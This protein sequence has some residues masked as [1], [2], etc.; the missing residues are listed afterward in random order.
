M[1]PLHVV[2]FVHGSCYEKDCPNPS[3]YS[4]FKDCS[5]CEV[6]DAWKLE[7]S[8]KAN[9]LKQSLSLPDGTQPTQQL[10][11]DEEKDDS[12]GPSKDAAPVAPV[13]PAP[14]P[15]SRKSGLKSKGGQVA[16][17]PPKKASDY[18]YAAS[19]TATRLGT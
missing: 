4:Y 5:F 9:A 14:P 7:E 16:V 18:R 3:T 2:R 10:N 15:P 13:A 17:R 19:L 12:H 8:R 11:E 6:C 1:P